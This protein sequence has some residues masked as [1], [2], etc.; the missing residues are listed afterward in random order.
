MHDGALASMRG[1]IESARKFLRVNEIS[2]AISAMGMERL[3]PSL[4]E[5][6]ASDLS[7]IR[8]ARSAW[9]VN[10]HCAAVNRAY[11]VF[12][13]FIEAVLAD[14]ITERSRR[15]K[16]TD[17]PQQIRN[18]YSCGMAEILR[19]LSHA[20]Y[21][22][23]S[24]G[25]LISGLNDALRGNSDYRLYPECLTFHRNNFRW[26]ELSEVFARCGVDN[27]KDWI[28][29]SGRLQEFF[30]TSDRISELTESKLAE[31]IGYRNDASHG[32]VDV[33]QIL[34]LEA[35]EAIFDFIEALAADL[36][37]LVRDRW[38]EWLLSVDQAK[39]VG[40]ISEK[41]HSNIRIVICEGVSLRVG[42]IVIVRKPRF[43]R[44]VTVDEL[45][46]DGVDCPKV[47]VSSSREIGIKFSHPVPL[48]SKLIIPEKSTGFP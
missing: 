14:W 48:Q 45:Q 13:R 20:R 2:R 22:H 16:Y 26:S 10:D 1:E 12:E 5:A 6:V 29:H 23:L 32:A 47:A 25:D 37:D 39:D 40:S 3:E 11:A 27:L 42:Q 33:D 18:S 30:E 7:D 17:L 4:L 46:L 21:S 38:V 35:L 41:F 19:S 31:L 8:L 43:C 34:G 36:M 28:S 44:F 15:S 9:R 24:E